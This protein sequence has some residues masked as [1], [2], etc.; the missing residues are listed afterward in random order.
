MVALYRVFAETYEGMAA[1]NSGN[2]QQAC[3][4]WRKSQDQWGLIE[5]RWGVLDSDRGETR[6]VDEGVQRCEGR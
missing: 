4:W 3:E 2:L 6:Q 5:E 1:D